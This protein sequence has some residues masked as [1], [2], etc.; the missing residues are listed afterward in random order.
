MRG[1]YWGAGLGTGE[2]T[3]LKFKKRLKM[4]SK[5]VK[6]FCMYSISCISFIF[7]V[8]FRALIFSVFLCYFDSMIFNVKRWVKFSNELNN[9]V[10]FLFN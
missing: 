1:V 10:L 6:V 9:R 3:M 2:D 7:Q 8:S 5:R 4:D